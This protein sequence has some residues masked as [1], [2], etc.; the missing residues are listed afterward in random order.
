[1]LDEPTVGLDPVLRRDL[2]RLFH[3]LADGGT[4]LLVSSHVMDEAVRCDR[5]LL[6]REGRLVADT[7]PAELRARTGEEE[8]ESAFLRLVE[9][10][11]R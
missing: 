3:E 1:V 7:T 9:E 2:W 10:E 6:M 5:L 8:M 4:T 11:A